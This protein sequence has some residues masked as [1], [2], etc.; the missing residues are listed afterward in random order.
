[1]VWSFERPSIYGAHSTAA[2]ANEGSESVQIDTE[3]SVRRGI[4]HCRAIGVGSRRLHRIPWKRTC[5][6]GNIAARTFRTVNTGLHQSAPC[7]LAL[8]ALKANAHCTAA[9]EAASVF[10][11]R[12]CI[13]AR[14]RARMHA[15]DGARTALFV[16]ACVSYLCRAWL[17]EERCVSNSFSKRHLSSI[18]TRR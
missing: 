12:A 14:A 16:H 13:H 6:P 8:Y 17:L 10:H 4:Q 11:R 3:C 18:V 9:A 5:V 1:M 2:V 7:T 15:C